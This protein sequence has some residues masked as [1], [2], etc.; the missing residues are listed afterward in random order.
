M[1]T[2]ALIFDFHGVIYSN[3]DWNVVNQRV[4][5]DEKKKAEFKKLV[6]GANRG[7]ISGSDFL[8]RISKLAEDALHPGKS[9]ISS[10]PSVN[11]SVL[12]LI[13]KLKFSYKIGLLSN[14]GRSSIDRELDAAGGAD[15]Y[16]DVTMASSDTNLIKPARG[17]FLGMVEKLGSTIDTTLVIDDSPRHIQ[18]AKEIGFKTIQFS[19]AEQLQVDLQKLRVQ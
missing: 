12:S 2:K 1:A 5:G 13:K 11:H 18:G 16:F 15:Q 3:L 7:Q 17:A 10:A 9:V 19:D 8:L 4:Y 6:Q 14:G